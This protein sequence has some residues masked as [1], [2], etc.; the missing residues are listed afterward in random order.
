MGINHLITANTILWNARVFYLFDPE[1]HR[2]EI[3][4]SVKTDKAPARNLV[5]M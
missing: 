4:Q 3:W 5:P 1:G 2:I